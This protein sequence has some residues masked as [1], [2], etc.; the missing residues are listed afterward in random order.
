LR[1]QRETAHWVIERTVERI[2]CNGW[3]QRLCWRGRGWRA[4]VAG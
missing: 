4:V 3:A 2:R 1:S